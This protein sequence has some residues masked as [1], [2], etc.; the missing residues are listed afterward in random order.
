MKKEENSKQKKEGILKS[1]LIEIRESIFFELTWRILF[2][3]P[4]MMIR[5]IKNLF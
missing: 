4:R 1:I 2:F 3:I 5:I